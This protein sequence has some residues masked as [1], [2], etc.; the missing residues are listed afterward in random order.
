MAK[1]YTI[2]TGVEV[3]FARERS[4][5]ITLPSGKKTEIIDDAP[6]VLAITMAQHTYYFEQTEAGAWRDMSGD[7]PSI[8]GLL[9][10]EFEGAAISARAPKF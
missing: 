6:A 5:I 7:D 2:G 3:L 10:F 9:L 1:K 4:V 8:H